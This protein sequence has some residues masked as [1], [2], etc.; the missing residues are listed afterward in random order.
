MPQQGRADEPEGVELETRERRRS[1]GRMP[2]NLLVFASFARPAARRAATT[3]FTW[4]RSPPVRGYAKPVHGQQR[5]NLLA[6]KPQAWA[7]SS[8]A[9]WPTG[10]HA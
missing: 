9:G 6:E 3:G 4:G 10:C 1:A 5:M 2:L 8:G 7:G